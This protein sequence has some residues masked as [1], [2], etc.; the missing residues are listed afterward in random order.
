MKKSISTAKAKTALALTGMLTFALATGAAQAQGA[1][2]F[3]KGKTVTI[4]IGF[5]PGGGYDANARMLARHLGKFIPGHPNVIAANM[6]GAGSLVAANS[7]YNAGAKDGTSL[8]IFVVRLM[9][10]S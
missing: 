3:F 8:V 5:P 2:E 4:N 1:A 10:I 9:S 7:V 6:P